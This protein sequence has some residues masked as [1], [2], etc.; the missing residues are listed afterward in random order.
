M[1]KWRVDIGAVSFS[2]DTTYICPKC[3]FTH[4]FGEINRNVYS[5]CPVCG[6]KLI[7][8]WEIPVTDAEE[9]FT[10]WRQY[11]V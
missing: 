2:G 3:N 4:L 8:P 9:F 1:D 6:E 10:E 5:E 11:E 7:Y